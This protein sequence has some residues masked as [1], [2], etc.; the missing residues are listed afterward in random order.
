[1]ISGKKSK[2]STV[3]QI[4]SGAFLVSYLIP[5]I[6]VTL[7]SKLPWVL[8]A[9]WLPFAPWQGLANRAIWSRVSPW[10]FSFLSIWTVVVGLY[11]YSSPSG[12]GWPVL[13]CAVSVWMGAFMGMCHASEVRETPRGILIWS[14]ILVSLNAFYSL[15]T[16]YTEAGAARVA[17]APDA[18]AVKQHYAF[19]GVGEYRL[20]T[21]LAVLAP[22]L[23]GVV[24]ARFTKLTTVA[25]IGLIGILASIALSTF[26]G[27]VSVATIGIITSLGLY[28]FRHRGNWIFVSVT[29]IGVLVCA[30]SLVALKDLRQIDMVASKIQALFSG[31]T[32]AGVVQGDM[33]SRGYLA[34]LSLNSFLEN[35]FF[36][37]GIAT[38]TE[39]NELYRLVGGHSSWL[40]QLAEFGLVGFSP[41]LAFW[42]VSSRNAVCRFRA[43]GNAVD[44]GL[45]GMVVGYTVC[46]LVNPVVFV[47]SVSVPVAFLVAGIVRINKANPQL[48]LPGSWARKKA[49][50]GPARYTE[51]RRETKSDTSYRERHI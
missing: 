2:V 23:L 50:P 27:S 45:V 14:I 7:G 36:G 17:M 38:M 41:F 44:A 30:I 33:T 9:L 35:P 34:T 20:Y 37:V 26:T 6:T 42:I 1:M 3:A 16:L 5:A 10:A 8:F 12:I 25:F 28:N 21:A 24:I 22:I 51:L 4:L 46:G 48:V 47:D 39:N 49:G 19:L 11:A 32:A 15:P 43:T 31:V 13:N 29:S 18:L 40:D